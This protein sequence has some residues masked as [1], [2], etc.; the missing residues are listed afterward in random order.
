MNAIGDINKQAALQ[1]AHLDGSVQS[2]E[3]GK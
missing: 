3:T 1:A 2:Y